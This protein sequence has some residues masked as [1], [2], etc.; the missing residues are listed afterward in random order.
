M[1]TDKDMRSISELM[2]LDTYQGMTDD[3]INSVINY[4]INQAV[5]RLKADIRKECAAKVSKQAYELSRS[6]ATTV[7]DMVESITGNNRPILNSV[8]DSND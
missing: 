2:I 6:T 7:S 3:E 5:T 1:T 8:G 4:R